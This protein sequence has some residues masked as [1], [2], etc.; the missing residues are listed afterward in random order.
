MKS[1]LLIGML[2]ILTI[3][4]N[5]QGC[6]SGGSGSPIA[7]GASQGVLAE[8]QVELGGN[9]QHIQTNK[10]YTG[11]KRI[12][13]TIDGFNSNYLYMRFAYGVSKKLTMSVENGYFFNKTQIGL[14]KA[15]T[16]KSSGFGDLILFPRYS[17]Y[18]KNTEKT[19]TE[20]TIGVG[21]KIPIGKY[22]DSTVTYTNPTTGKKSYTTSPPI[23]QPT[24]GAND[25][26]FYGFVY[27]G[28][29]AKQYRIFANFLYIKKGW[30]ALGQR[31]GDYSS[32]G[33][34]ASKTFFRKVGVTF[35]VKGEITGQ[36]KYDKN[37]DMLALYNIDV[38][39]TGNK[40]LSFV[41]QVSYTR[42]NVTIYALSDLPFYQ[43][44]N[45]TQIG[46]S[47]QATLGATYR[48]YFTK[49]NG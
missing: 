45:G 28:Y 5:A 8:R 22:N 32:V 37:I 41:P 47:V 12:S 42:K 46:S 4:S 20:I 7:G 44:V 35:Q 38:N 6:C 34:F 26:I 33:L 48:F 49:M 30:N 29:P 9:Y 19:R 24:N 1:Y 15:D 13:N 17:V 16:I 18:T 3:K 39:S 25:I 27:R 36:M 23:I 43:H 40:R 31:F 14:D 11:N 2:A 21:Y 10:F